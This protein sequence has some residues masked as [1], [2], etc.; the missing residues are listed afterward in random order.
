MNIYVSSIIDKSYIRYLCTSL[1][2]DSN[3]VKTVTFFYD[4]FDQ[5][6]EVTI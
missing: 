6:L 5:E 1:T 4:T 2:I 3:V